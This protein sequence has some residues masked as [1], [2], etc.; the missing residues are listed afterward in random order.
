MG[1]IIF[2]HAAPA[3]GKTF[4]EKRYISTLYRKGKKDKVLWLTP[5]RTL[6]QRERQD[7]IRNF[8]LDHRD[9]HVIKSK[10]EAGC[11]LIRNSYSPLLSLIACSRCPT[12]TCWY[13]QMINHYMES[14]E[15]VWIA[16]HRFLPFSIFG[17]AKLVVVDEYDLMIPNYLLQPVSRDEVE[18]L[19][20]NRIITKQDIDKLYKK[21]M[22]FIYNGTM[23]ITTRFFILHT[24]LYSREVRLLSATPIPDEELN[25]RLFVV[26]PDEQVVTSTIENAFEDERIRIKTAPPYIP[27]NVKI[28]GLCISQKIY[29][30][31]RMRR[32]VI[33]EIIPELIKRLD[34]K[35]TVITGSKRE[36]YRLKYIIERKIPYRKTVCEEVPEYSML[37][38]ASIRLIVVSGKLSRG[39]DLD[40]DVVIALWQ[41]G[42][43]TKSLEVIEF[44]NNIF[45][46]IGGEELYKYMSYRRHVQTLFRTIRRYDRPHLLILLDRS[47]FNALSYFT[48]T[49]FLLKHIEI[50]SLDDLVNAVIRMR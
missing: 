3:T 21:R 47:W 4:Y 43:P 6:R 19:I 16:T 48:T 42:E 39:W 25:L 31:S 37:E 33:E 8:G 7:L 34:G 22:L 27:A 29:M 41:Y 46:N 12:K 1:D 24:A 2:R 38:T 18:I 28:R 13:R 50:E 32:T 17:G 44:L 40:S 10:E 5:L 11:N 36:M 45:P 30:S 9:V 49:R 14:D 23:Y 35:I 26:D 20:K 15:G